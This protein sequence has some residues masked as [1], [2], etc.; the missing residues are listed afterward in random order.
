MSNTFVFLFVNDRNII[1]NCIR[2]RDCRNQNIV[3][4]Q[5]F[6]FTI[7]TLSR[8]DFINNR[9]RCSINRYSAFE[10]SVA[11]CFDRVAKYRVLAV[12]NR[13]LSST[14]DCYFN[15]VGI[16]MTRVNVVI[17]THTWRHV[18][19]IRMENHIFYDCSTVDCLF[20]DHAFFVA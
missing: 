18:S 17:P 6:I 11:F 3:F 7:A 12:I 19:T 5:P 15:A 16:R 8:Y 13:R 20:T 1:R 2:S 10:R 4:S 9:L 14:I